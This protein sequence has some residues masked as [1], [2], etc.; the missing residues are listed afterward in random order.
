[1]KKLIQV[2][3]HSCRTFQ[4]YGETKAKTDRNPFLKCR[5][6]LERVPRRIVRWTRDRTGAQ[7]SRSGAMEHRLSGILDGDGTHLLINWWLTGQL[8]TQGKQGRYFI[9]VSPTAEKLSVALE[10]PYLPILT[11]PVPVD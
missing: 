7:A 2:N 3:T 4:I 9:L 5:H 8:T 10:Q 11:L 1:M 6:R